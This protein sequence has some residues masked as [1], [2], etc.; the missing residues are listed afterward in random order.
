[1]TG[2]DRVKLVG[3]VRLARVKCTRL[4]RRP[5]RTDSALTHHE[6]KK[7]GGHIAPSSPRRHNTDALERDYNYNI[8]MRNGSAVSVAALCLVAAAV[9]E[10]SLA[11]TLPTQQQPHSSSSSIRPRIAIGTR[12]RSYR[13]PSLGRALFSS[14]IV[15]PQELLSVAS[16][17]SS[18]NQQNDE[19]KLTAAT[20]ST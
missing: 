2:T 16:S 14:S 20:T 7:N 19:A 3:R 9:V 4:G 10:R 8:I 6:A 11:F 1:M 15:D 13:H 12:T 5:C 17:S 18:A